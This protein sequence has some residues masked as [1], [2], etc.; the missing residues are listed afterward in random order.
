[1]LRRGL[2]AAAVAVAVLGTA[3]SLAADRGVAVKDD[4]FKP[5]SLKIE[6]GTR[7]TWTWRGE[8]RHNVVVALGPSEFRSKIKREGTYGHTFKKTGTWQLTC[9]VHSGMNMKIVVK[10]QL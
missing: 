2:P 1:M 9:T 6:K 5:S 8:G 10:K 4:F 7:V 3:P